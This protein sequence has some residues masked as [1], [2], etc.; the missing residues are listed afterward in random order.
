MVGF[1]RR[2]YKQC[3][4][5]GLACR[6]ERTPNVRGTSMSMEQVRAPMK[7]AG[8]RRE[9]AWC[10]ASS[11]QP[12]GPAQHRPLSGIGFVPITRRFSPTTSMISALPGSVRI[13]FFDCQSPKSPGPIAGP[14]TMTSRYRKRASPACRP[15]AGGLHFRG[16]LESP[17]ANSG[18]SG[19]LEVEVQG[20]VRGEVPAEIDPLET[21]ANL[22]EGIP[23]N[24]EH[25]LIEFPQLGLILLP[26]DFR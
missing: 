19:L 13:A 22:L 2:R 16:V 20:H 4:R 17:S 25:L 26:A 9:R 5:P 1:A 24:G 12:G 8:W 21:S 7:E 10:P 14:W 11:Q 18:G 23:V 6:S 15:L 3:L